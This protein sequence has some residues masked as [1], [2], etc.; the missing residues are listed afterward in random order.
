MA[1]LSK[2]AEAVSHEDLVLLEL[3]DPLRRQPAGQGAFGIGRR[4]RRRRRWDAATEPRRRRRLDH[5]AH[6]DERLPLAQVRVLRRFGHRQHRCKAGVAALEQLAPLRARARLERSRQN[7][8]RALP[9]RRIALFA[10]FLRRNLQPPQQLCMK[11][12]LE[13]RRILALH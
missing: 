9:I 11:S 8:T 6:V 5:A 13:A 1:G 12:A 3:G 7:G 4:R 10:D 2:P